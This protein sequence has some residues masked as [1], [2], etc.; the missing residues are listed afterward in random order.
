M[1]DVTPID[2]GIEAADGPEKTR[3]YADVKRWSEKLSQARKH[4][5]E[6]RKQ[7]AKDRRYARGD[8]G[9]EVDTNLIGTNIDILESFLYSKDP[10]VDI[11]PARACQPPGLDA[12]QEAAEAAF[13]NS[14]EAQAQVRQEALMQ[15]QPVADTASWAAMR[16]GIDPGQATQQVLAEA[17]AQ[18][19]AAAA[20]QFIAEQVAL[21]QKR[22]TKRKRDAD[23]YAE[24]LEIVVSRLWRDA[25]L[26]HRGR[27]MVRSGLTIGVGLLKASWQERT[28]PSPE[29]QK[30]IND[31]QDNI[32]RAAAQ[33]AALEDASGDDL[34]AQT[35]EYQRQLTALKGQAEQ[36]IARGFA[37]DQV[38]GENFQI[39]PGWQIANHLDAPWNADRVPMLKSEA[40]ATFGLSAEQMKAAK[41]YGARKPEMI[42]TT[43]ALVDPAPEATDADAYIAGDTATEEGT[44][45]FVMVWEIWD[46]EAS[47]ILTM[48]EGVRCWVKPAFQPTATTRFYPYFAYTTSEV[49]GQRHPQ[50]LVTRSA[51][52]VDEYNRIG[53]AEAEHRRRILPALMFDATGVDEPSARKLASPAIAAK[54]PITPTRPGTDLR[55]LFSEIPY[56]EMNPAVYDRQRIK[57]ELDSIWGIQ[58]ALSGSV[59]TPKTATEAEIQQSGF[60]ARTGGRRGLLEWLL[61]DLA[62]YTAEVGRAH[63][64]A[65]DVRKIAGEDSLWPAYKGAADLADMVSIEIRAGSSGKPNTTADREAWAAQLP[66][67]QGAIVQIAGLRNSTPTDLADCLEQLLRITAERSGDRLNIDQLLPKPGPAPMPVA[68]G[69]PNAPPGD[70]AAPAPPAAAPAAA[71]A[72]V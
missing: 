57:L 35:A 53:S 15:A 72:P 48:I 71:A 10:D 5:E 16:N 12:L 39:P 32:K 11:M 44:G 6:A 25:S 1:D 17:S 9:F 60:T 20:E 68:P 67:L 43:S 4:D 50:S 14:P 23:T 37:I 64:D 40:M 59:Q 52:L 65:D 45:E 19:E 70:P 36:V 58:E 69:D 33:R 51:K 34:E 55:T 61:G 66:I 28:A 63:L 30:A 24:T 56:P 8:S 49:D 7:Y 62:Q 31:L 21:M 27:R 54:V 26:K 18:M 3:E 2:Q 22:Y 47:T 13:N 41:I 46:R 29:T 38:A 42:R